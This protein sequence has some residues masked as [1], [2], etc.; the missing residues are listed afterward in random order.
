MPG[1][2][3]LNEGQAGA[4]EVVTSCVQTCRGLG[5]TVPSGRGIPQQGHRS[6]EDTVG[7]APDSGLRDPGLRGKRRHVERVM[8]PRIPSG[9]GSCIARAS[10]IRDDGGRIEAR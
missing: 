8:A 5:R 3:E 6:G 4:G 10:L 1:G 9:R 7:S 2:S